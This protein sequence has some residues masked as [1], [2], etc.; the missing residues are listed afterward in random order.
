VRRRVWQQRHVPG[1]LERDA[2]AA[3]VARTGAGLAPRFDLTTI[4]EIA[5]QPRDILIVNLDNVINAERADL[6]PPCVTST[7]TKTTATTVAE[8]RPLA[9]IAAAVAAAIAK[10]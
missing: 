7:A 5:V 8:A 6:A 3:L 1:V 9:A 4:G 2:Q 10:A